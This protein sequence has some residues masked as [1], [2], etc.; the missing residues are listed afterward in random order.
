[1]GKG[2]FLSC[3]LYS[4]GRVWW[5]QVK[6]SEYNKVVGVVHI[7]LMMRGDIIFILVLKQG[8][9]SKSNIECHRGNTIL[10]S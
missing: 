3:I 9:L 4:A 10:N 2:H 5:L 8:E 7:D 6:K 1:M